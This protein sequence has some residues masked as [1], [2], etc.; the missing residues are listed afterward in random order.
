MGDKMTF[1]R[2]FWKGVFEGKRKK[3]KRNTK[4][5]Y[6]GERTGN[7]NGGGS[8]SRCYKC[9][10]KKATESREKKRQWR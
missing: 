2:T 6:M 10:H 1:R 8:A 7:G 3:P 9:Y 5:V 4:Y